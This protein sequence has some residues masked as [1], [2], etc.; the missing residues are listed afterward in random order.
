M[1][2]NLNIGYLGPKGTYS[3]RAADLYSPKLNKIPFNSINEVL[4]SLND[5]TSD[6]VIVPLE[7]SIQGSIVEVLDF[8]ADEKNN[9]SIIGELELNINHSIYTL[10]KYIDNKFE[11]IFSHPQALGQSYNYINDNYPHAELK[12]SNSTADSMNDLEEYN[13]PGAFIGPPWLKNN[14][15][16]ILLDENI[17]SVKNNVTRF[18]IISSNSLEKITNNDKTS[19]VISF[20]KDAPGSLHVALG[21]FSVSKINMTKIESRPTKEKL[22]N[23]YFFID[24]EGNAKD[25][26]LSLCLNIIEKTCNLKILGSY[27]IFDN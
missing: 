20:D 26:K 18:V 19:L 3:S 13:I 14:E 10:E 5:K 11:V 23:Y 9:F 6:L 15:K 21:P 22:G 27:P 4:G 17:Q 24:V 1:D 8:L 7:N 16:V 25:E 2:D 12:V